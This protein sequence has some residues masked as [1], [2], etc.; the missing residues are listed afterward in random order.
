MSLIKTISK[1]DDN[2]FDA[3]LYV[4]LSVVLYFYLSMVSFKW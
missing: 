4:A 2:P 3:E 1:S